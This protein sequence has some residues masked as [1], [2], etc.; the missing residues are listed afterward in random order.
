MNTYHLT[1][2][3]SNPAKRDGYYHLH[4]YRWKTEAQMS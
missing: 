4:F 3:C 1:G 2:A